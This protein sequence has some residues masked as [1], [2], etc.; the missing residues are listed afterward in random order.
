MSEKT[1]GISVIIPSY[2][3]EKYIGFAIQS[4][5]DQT[6]DDWELVIVDDGSTDKSVEV[7]KKYN[8]P[9]IKIFVQSNHDAPYTI[10]RGIS[11]SRGKHIAILNS[12][13]VFEPLK[14]EESMRTLSEGYDF[15]FGK[16][17]VIDE[18]N[19]RMDESDERVRW[20]N[21]K[22]NNST[23]PDTL[24]KLFLN[25]NYIVTPSNFVFRRSVIEKIGYFHEK[26]HVSHDF[27]FLVK[28]FSKGLK[29]KFIPKYHARY[30]LHSNNTLSKSPAE[31]FVEACYSIAK[32][33]KNDNYDTSEL[34]LSVFREPIVSNLLFYYLTLSDAD[35]EDVVCNKD[36]IHRNKLII[37]T[38]E[39]LKKP[40]LTYSVSDVSNKD[41][42]DLRA[43]I[44]EKDREVFQLK[45]DLH[46]IRTS[47]RWK[48]PNYI[49]KK[50]KSSLS[51]LKNINLE[52]RG[53]PLFIFREIL[54]RIS[55]SILEIL[56]VNTLVNK[57]IMRDIEIYSR[58]NCVKNLTLQK[59]VSVVMLTMERLDDTKK[60]IENLYEYVKVPFELVI[61]DNGSGN[62]T[63]D[64]LKKIKKEKDN[65]TIIFEKTNLGCAGGRKKA[66]SYAKGDYVV[67]IDN[68]II[69]TPFFLENLIDTLEK[70]K[71]AAGVCCKVVYPDGKIQFNG[72]ELSIDEEFISYKLIDNG[73]KY[74]DRSTF[75]YIECDWIPGGA[76]IWRSEI[77][78][79]YELDIEMRGSH[80]DAEF[81]Y[82][83]KNAGYQLYNCPKAIVIHNHITFNK[84]AKKNKKYMSAR[85]SRENIAAAIRRFYCKHGLIVCDPDVF[86]TFGLCKSNKN[87]I[88][89]FM[90]K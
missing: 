49:Y 35:I 59:K 47:L 61:L 36:N 65:I 28:L 66:F 51:L 50:Y 58:L 14:L 22:L 21:N 25:I 52:T 53:N 54:K 34:R 74:N 27:N 87:E 55:T 1:P 45:I 68:D 26:L 85:Y 71:N 76:T 6:F 80:E 13:D 81:S 43:M 20:I 56:Y 79:K 69:V 40:E 41:K 73:K 18:N 37:L 57:K 19:N 16:L 60:T 5:L 72:G 2:N 64:Y 82:V 8:D 17:S 83:L 15:V 7:I 78:K 67:S 48:M 42:R 32:Y 84:K 44:D 62:R 31:S 88:I 9:R 33:F 10:N 63:V 3:H 70:N 89:D 77:L 90:E 11:E 86:E 12:D 75:N 24:S 38:K 23:D 39:L 46:N 29:V 30:R 4:V